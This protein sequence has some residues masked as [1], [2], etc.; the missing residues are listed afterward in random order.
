MGFA[1]ERAMTV[2]DLETPVLLLEVEKMERN[3]ARMHAQ[4]KPFS[5]VFRPHMKTCKAIE[6]ARASMASPTGPVSISTLAEADFF[7]MHGVTDMIYTVGIAPNKF[8]HV[9]RLMREGIALKILL[10]AEDAARQLVAFAKA[11]GAIFHVLI[12]IDVDGH[13]SGLTPSDPRLI[14][15]AS[16]LRDGGQH[17]AGVLTHAG[18]SYECTSTEG[19]AEAA[20]QER[21][22]IVAAAENLRKAGFSCEMVSLGSTPTA[23]FV[24]NLDGVT[25][26]RAGVF[27]FQDLLMAGIGVCKPEDIAVSV[28]ASVIGHQDE[29][30]WAIIDAG[31]LALSRDRGTA[32]QTIDQGYGLV[33]DVDGHIIEDLIVHSTNQEHGVLAIRPNGRLKALPPLPV[34]TLVRILPNHACATVAPYDCYHVMRNGILTETWEHCKG[35]S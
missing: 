31:W 12:E 11:Q 20:E 23:T 16:L 17:V 9:L 4:L 19:I 35:W 32:S 24:R 6:P 13:R 2:Y 27:I 29:K 18:E 26:V 25:D 28:L 14:A 3:I 22:G 7:A 1:V 10:D 21:L 15:I 30:G 34:G 5:V 33:C 8:A